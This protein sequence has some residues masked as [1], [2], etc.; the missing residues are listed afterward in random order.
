MGVQ[1]HKNMQGS[2]RQPGIMI[3]PIIKLRSIIPGNCMLF[4]IDFSV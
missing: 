2:V 4:C 3:I 1:N